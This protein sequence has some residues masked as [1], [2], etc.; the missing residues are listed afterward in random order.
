LRAQ[1]GKLDAYLRTSALIGTPSIQSVHDY[2]PFALEGGGRL[3]PTAAELV[4][5]LAILVGVSRFSCMGAANS[6][7]LRFDNDVRMWHFIRRYTCVPFRRFLGDVRRVYMQCLSAALHGPLFLIFTALCMRAMPMQWHAFMYH[8]II[9][10]I[11][12]ADMFRKCTGNSLCIDY[13]W[14]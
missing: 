4:D 2:Y 1:Q 7:S 3:A 11:D 8:T 6:R 9:L 12:A 14:H 13:M 5:R 10:C